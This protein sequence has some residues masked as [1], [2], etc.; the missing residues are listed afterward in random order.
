MRRIISS[1]SYPFSI[2][3]SFGFSTLFFAMDMV[4]AETSGLPSTD[5]SPSLQLPQFPAQNLPPKT[6][7]KDIE[8]IPRSCGDI[9]GLPE[10]NV[11]IDP[12]A[13]QD[14][15]VQFVFSV[16][17][18]R[19]KKRKRCGDIPRLHAMLIGFIGLAPLV[20]HRVSYESPKRQQALLLPPPSHCPKQPAAGVQVWSSSWTHVTQMKRYKP[21]PKAVLC[22]Q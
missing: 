20:N 12:T 5:P 13:S 4:Q 3:A 9:S 19:R 10:G 2:F 11:T 14:D 6:N 15:E 21:Q 1:S 16:P 22:L 18:R 7:V 8:T 17:R